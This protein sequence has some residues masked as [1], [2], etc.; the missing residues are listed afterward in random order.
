MLAQPKPIAYYVLRF[1]YKETDHLYKFNSEYDAMHYLYRCFWKDVICHTLKEKMIENDENIEELRNFSFY[2]LIAYHTDEKFVYDIYPIRREP[3]TI[4]QICK[5]MKSL[6]S[7]YKDYNLVCAMEV[8]TNDRLEDRIFE[9]YNSKKSD[10]QCSKKW[11]IP[12]LNV[13]CCNG[14]LHKYFTKGYIVCVIDDNNNFIDFIVHYKQMFRPR[15]V[16]YSD[17][18]ELLKSVMDNQTV[19]A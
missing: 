9:C 2:E 15:N 5:K 14:C 17:L 13:L 3:K 1:R 4:F 6:E 12:A 8:N 11:Y 16:H 18:P 10:H 7:K 19:D